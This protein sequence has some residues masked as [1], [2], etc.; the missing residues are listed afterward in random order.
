MYVWRLPIGSFA[1][2]V[3]AAALLAAIALLLRF[4]QLTT[5]AGVRAVLFV[6]CIVAVVFSPILV[7]GI[8]TFQPR[9][10]LYVDLSPLKLWLPAVFVLVLLSIAKV[11]FPSDVRPLDSMR[12]R[13]RF[14]AATWFFALLNLINLCNPGWCDRFGFPFRYNW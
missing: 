2:L 4:R 14:Y 5:N 11:A 13:T 1:Q 9:Q 6:L 8:V 12:W 3:C 10:G 7:D